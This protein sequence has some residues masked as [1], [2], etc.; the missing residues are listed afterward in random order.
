MEMS[1]F[2]TL[3]VLMGLCNVAGIGGGAIDT[4]IVMLFF[5]FSIVEAIAITNL[6]IFFGAVT[7]FLYNFNERHPDK[8]HVVIV[9]YPL[10]TI[11]MATTLAG[12]Q[13]GAMFILRTFP[14]ILIQ[15]VLELLLILLAV[16][17]F[18]KAF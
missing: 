12:S 5:K 17:S 15:S 9:D 7:R 14:S 8:P 10:A 4:P 3:A 11:M 18:M 13:I 2:V 1:G 6:I 16:N